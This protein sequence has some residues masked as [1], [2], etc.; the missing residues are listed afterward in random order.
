MSINID[1]SEH[2]HEEE[3]DIIQH[4]DLRDEDSKEDQEE[5]VTK[6]NK[7]IQVGKILMVEGK[8]QD[9]YK[10]VYKCFKKISNNKKGDGEG[11]E[12]KDPRILQPAYYFL[13]E[14][15]IANNEI[16]KAQSFLVSAYWTITKKGE[17]NGDHPSAEES[18]DDLY[19]KG[20]RHSALAKLF[21]KQVNSKKK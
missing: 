7:A 9:A 11:E 21:T 6:L 3:D 17:K 18:K 12:G 4:S 20:L 19:I 16:Q 14:A 13:V 8:S 10:M 2:H 15:S 1:Y 5:L